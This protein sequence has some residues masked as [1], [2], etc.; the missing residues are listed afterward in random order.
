MIV[1]CKSLAERTS[2]S[3][4]ALDYKLKKKPFIVGFIHFQE[5][6]RFVLYWYGCSCGELLYRYID[7]LI[8]PNNIQISLL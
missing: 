2:L 4:F 8:D 5:N 3:A 1:L 7:E 6:P